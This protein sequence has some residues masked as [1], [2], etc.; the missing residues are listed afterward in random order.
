MYPDSATFGW[1]QIRLESWIRVSENK[2]SDIKSVANIYHHNVN[3]N[4]IRFHQNA[5]LYS[6]F[7]A[8]FTG[9]NIIVP[10]PTAQVKK[11]SYTKSDVALSCATQ[12]FVPY[13]FIESFFLLRHRK[14]PESRRDLLL[15]AAG[16]T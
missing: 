4:P 11:R 12:P 15:T 13:K 9:R 16:F 7:I 8:D 3:P 5:D 10:E 6:S 1:T 14:V 2:A